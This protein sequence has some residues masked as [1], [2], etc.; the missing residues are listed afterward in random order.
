[1]TAGELKSRNYKEWIMALLAIAS[2]GLVVVEDRMSLTPAQ[3]EFLSWADAGIW[4]IFVVDYTL[5]LYL[6]TTRWHYVKGHI[7]ELIAILPFNS[8]L[9]GLRVLRLLRLSRAAR[10]TRLLRLVRLVAYGGRM[11]LMLRQFFATHNFYLSVIFTTLFILFGSMAV[12]HFE[13][14]SFGDAI[15]WAFVTAT[16][17]GYGDISPTTTEGRFVAAF[18]MLTGIGFIG[19]LTGTVATFFL[20]PAPE[21]S[22]KAL[23]PHIELIIKQLQDFE[24]LSEEDVI[25]MGRVLVALQRTKMSV[26]GGDG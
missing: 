13:G 6:S 16:T 17:V 25:E 11:A 18:L 3:T 7:I 22:Q 1:M 19:L 23:N 20:A 24:S 12:S 2:V 10:L 26:G 14:M 15:W 4:T 9:K 8:L 5:G 21:N